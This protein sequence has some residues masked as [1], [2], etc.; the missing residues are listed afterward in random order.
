MARVKCYEGHQLRIKAKYHYG[1]IRHERSLTFTEFLKA[2][3]DALAEIP[4]NSGRESAV[5]SCINDLTTVGRGEFGWTTYT[6]E[7]N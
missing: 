5:F 7:G 6:L 1:S 3:Q 2:M 4:G